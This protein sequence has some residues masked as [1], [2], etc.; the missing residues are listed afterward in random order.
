MQTLCKYKLYANPMQRSMQ[1][2]LQT[3]CKVYANS[4]QTGMLIE[5]KFYANCGNNYVLTMLFCVLLHVF[6][7]L[8]KSYIEA[9]P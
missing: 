4:I 7:Q 2:F 9:E 5:C 1:N 3:L 6:T 8:F